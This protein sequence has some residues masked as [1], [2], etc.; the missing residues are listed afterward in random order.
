MV[1]VVCAFAEESNFSFENSVSSVDLIF[2]SVKF[3]PIG[4]QHLC[5]H[6]H[7]SPVLSPGQAGDWTM[8]IPS[9]FQSFSKGKKWCHRCYKAKGYQNNESLKYG[10]HTIV[11]INK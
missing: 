10:T 1:I 11:K 3:V 9:I 8:D 4:L 6:L 5:T 7:P 2:Q